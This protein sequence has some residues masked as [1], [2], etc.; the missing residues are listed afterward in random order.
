MWST[1]EGNSKP[2]QY[3]CLEN[4]K[5]SM[6]RQKDR[7]QRDEL[8]RSVGAQY[9]TGDQW[10]NNSRKNEGM[11]PK[12]KQYPA[13][14]VTADRSKVRCC[15][16][17][18]C[19]GTWNVRSMN[20]GKLEVVKQEL[21]RVKAD[22]LVISELKWTGMGE[23]NSDDHYIYCCRQEYLRRNGVAIMV[24]KSLKCSTCMQSQKQQNNLCSFPRQTIQYHSN[25]SLCSDQ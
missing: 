19:I 15:K 17:Q 2:V 13:V 9:A 23:F 1:G 20:Q 8:P 3:S 12:Q 14:D 22:I 24:N 7:T 5:K 21:A 6:K 25:P 11:E 18:D 4:P 10:R 16:E